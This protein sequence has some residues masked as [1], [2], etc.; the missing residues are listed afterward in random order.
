MI[1][2]LLLVAHPTPMMTMATLLLKVILIALLMIGMKTVLL[3]MS[4]EALQKPHTLT[5]MT[6]MV[7]LFLSQVTP[8]NTIS[9]VPSLMK[10]P[11]PVHTPMMKTAG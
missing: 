6:T 5:S 10:I 4:G 9:M 3:M 2:I 1:I 8:S 7:G 11:I